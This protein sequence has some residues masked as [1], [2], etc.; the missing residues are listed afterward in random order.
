M[1]GGINALLQIREI[2]IDALNP[3][4]LACFWAAALQGYA[5]RPY[6]EAEVARLAAI[7]RAPDTDPQVALDG[8][9]PTI[10]FQETTECKPHR[11]RLHL[12]LVGGSRASEVERLCALGATVRDEHESYS[13]LQD[14]E[15]NEFCVQDPA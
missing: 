12:D 10:F 1:G 2:V 15:G 3:P 6:D 8:P 14:P 7:G 4:A 9:G 13:V 5:V 11:N